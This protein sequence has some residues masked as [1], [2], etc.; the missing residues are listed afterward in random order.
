MSSPTAPDITQLSETQQTA[1]QTYTAVTDQEPLAAIAL[2]QRCEWNVQIA[3]SRFFDGEPVSDPLAEA[4][5]AQSVPAITSRQTA[6]LQYE[7]L[8][9]ANPVSPLSARTSQENVVHRID[10]SSNTVPAYRPPFLL[11]ALFT[12]FSILFRI[13][14]TVLSPF[15]FL[16]P[17][18]LSRAFRNLLTL[19]SRPSRRQLPP[20]DTARRFIREFEET[21][22]PNPPL[23][24]VET[25]F[26]LTLDNCKKDSKFLLAVLVSPSHD[27]TH[28]W[29]RETLMSSQFHQFL[30]THEQELLLWGGSVQD[31]EGYQVATSLNCTKFPSTVL[32]CQ[33]AEAGGSTSQSGQMVVVMRAAGPLPANEL[34]A[35]LGSAVTAQQAQLT[36]SRAQR[37]E[38]QAQRSL[39]QEQDSAYERS[40]AQDRE[41]ARR[42]REEEEAKERAEK[43]AEEAALEVERREQQREQWRQWRKSRLLKEPDTMANTVRL[44]I[45]LAN[46]ER[47]IRKFAA[48][49]P[50]EELYAYVDCHDA[51]SPEGKND[52]EVTAPT[53]YKHEYN[54]RLVSPMPRNVINLEQAGSIGEKVGRGGNLIVEHLDGD[55]ENESDA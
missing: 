5:A 14:S 51:T 30:Q 48:D 55:D 46:G 26:N 10:T 23:P 18:F 40:L 9:A 42:R 16:L 1:L 29:V 39:R 25:G 2:L 47:L 43:Q 8:L 22:S 15:S 12:P 31:A 35:K 13:F 36:A 38:H 52:Q 6:N 11:S 4:R 21:Y 44:S 24:W 49:V 20:A 37:A 54:F 41:R 17:G 53:D 34:V 50:L 3:I 7:S 33:T 45:R 32:I 28:S 19:N 27:D